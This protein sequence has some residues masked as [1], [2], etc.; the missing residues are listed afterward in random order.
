MPVSLADSG[1]TVMNLGVRGGDVIGG[2]MGQEQM[3]EAPCW[4][5]CCRNFTQSSWCK[6]PGVWPQI[7]RGT[8]PADWIFCQVLHSLPLLTYHYSQKGLLLLCDI[9][10]PGSLRAPELPFYDKVSPTH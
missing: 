7:L 9:P 10:G 5:H 6:H 8:H 4:R 1:P 2:V 3:P